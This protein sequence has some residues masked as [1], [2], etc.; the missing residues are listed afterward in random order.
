MTHLSEQPVF[1][2]FCPSKRYI[3]LVDFINMSNTFE[4][5]N[6][7][8]LTKLLLMTI[9]CPLKSPILTLNL[10]MTFKWVGLC[11]KGLKRMIVKCRT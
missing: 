5:E 4:E 2:S 3:D 11:E 6:Q 7:S 1:Q 10:I 9:P 8:I